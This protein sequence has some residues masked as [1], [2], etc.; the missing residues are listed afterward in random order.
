MAS[1]ENE[2]N[3]EHPSVSEN[4]SLAEDNAELHNFLQQQSLQMAELQQQLNHLSINTPRTAQAPTPLAYERKERLP[5]DKFMGEL[6]TYL[7]WKW[8][9]KPKLKEDGSVIGSL[10]SQTHYVHSRLEGDALAKFQPWIESCA[11]EMCTPEEVFRQLD[12]LFLD[13]TRQARS[14]QWLNRNRQR[15]TPLANY[16]PD[17]D[18]KIREA[19]GQNWD[20]A[21]KINLLSQ[22][23]SFELL[24]LCTSHLMPSRYHDYCTHLRQLDNNLARFNAVHG[25]RPTVECGAEEH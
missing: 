4:R 7:A 17:F 8:K 2:M 9:A 24:K 10:L 5:L 13:P 6:S 12:V 21:M 15:K 19:G 14:M 3:Y 11:H 22:H 1:Y 20:D 25:S 23:I 18:S 16:L